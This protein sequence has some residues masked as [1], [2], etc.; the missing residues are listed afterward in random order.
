MTP[1]ET[2]LL[3]ERYDELIPIMNAHVNG[4]EIQYYDNG[5]NKWKPCACGPSWDRCSSDRVKPQSTLRPYTDA[6]LQEQVG[7]VLIHY[8][9]G[10]R[11]LCDA[12]VDSDVNM[13]CYGFLGGA[14]LLRLF[15]HL[16]GSPC[17]VTE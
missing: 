17:G 6:E 5:C 4:Q 8:L 13:A 14:E 16:D 12:C 11:Y 9:D 1:A 7:K 2:S 3:I 15:K 10:D